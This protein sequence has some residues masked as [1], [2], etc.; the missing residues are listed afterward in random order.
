MIRH[1]V[2]VTYGEPPTASYWAQLHYSWRILLG[3]T[4]S[5][6]PI[7]AAVLPLIALRR[8]WLRHRSWT[9]EAYGSPL[10]PL[11]RQQA[12]GLRHA[13]AALAPEIEWQVHVG[14]E[15]RNPLLPALL[16]GLPPDEPVDIVP[17]Y[18]ADSAFTHDIT[19]AAL[20][21]WLRRRNDG[22]TSARPVAVLPPMDEATLADVSVRHLRRLLSEAGAQAGPDTALV[23]AAHGT[24]LEPPRPMETGREATERL[25]HLIAAGLNGEFGLVVHGWLNH[26]YGGQ[27]TQPPI[28]EALRLVSENGFRRVFYYPYGFL[29]DN[30]E[31][32]LEGRIALRAR[33]ELEAI[34]LPCLN[35][36]PDYLQALAQQIL[37][38]VSARTAVK[39]GT[40]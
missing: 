37:S 15:F 36:S 19:R 10:E 18:V 17:M 11:T 33:P 38:G 9:G 7:P 4:R 5:V 24:L 40:A 29:A 1:V 28:E 25:A 14:Y 3:L 31:S 35:A 12:A 39:A 27:W 30:A 8:A 34:H 32:Q 6:A 16:D 21:A 13:L 22:G 2:L 20:Q 23:L 26:V